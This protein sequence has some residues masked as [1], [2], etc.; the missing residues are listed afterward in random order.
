MALEQEECL[1]MSLFLQVF[2]LIP[3]KKYPSLDF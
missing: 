2:H 1:S 3:K